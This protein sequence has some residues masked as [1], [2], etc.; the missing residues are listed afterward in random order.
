MTL[1]TNLGKDGS[2]PVN[3][4]LEIYNVMDIKFTLQS[5]SRD[6]AQAC[7]E[8]IK[9]EFSNR[10]RLRRESVTLVKKLYS[11]QDSREKA[12]SA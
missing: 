5:H 2:K 7:A 9:Q 6:W 12:Q 11:K 8:E 4:G 10:R 3:G 1:G